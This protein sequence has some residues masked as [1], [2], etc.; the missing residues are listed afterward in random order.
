MDTL[1]E[2]GG[3]TLEEGLWRRS[4]QQ[5]MDPARQLASTFLLRKNGTLLQSAQ[6]TTPEASLAR[7]RNGAGDFV[8]GEP[9]GAV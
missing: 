3:A 2:Q 4:N 8:S 1:S 5:T 6:S 7:A 9:I